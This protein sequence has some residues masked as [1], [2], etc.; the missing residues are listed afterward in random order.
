LGRLKKDDPLYFPEERLKRVLREADYPPGLIDRLI[1]IAYLPINRTDL[2]KG[3]DR[4]VVAEKEALE[5]L[6]RLGYSPA[7]A[8]LLRDILFSDKRKKLGT[9]SGQW[10]PRKITKEFRAGTITVRQAH[11]LLTNWY[12]NVDTALKVLEDAVMIREAETKALCI[13]AIRRRYMTGGITLA[14]ADGELAKLSIDDTQRE[15]LTAR[16]GCE[17]GSKAKE[18]TVRYIREWYME[19]IVSAGEFFTRLVFLGYNDNDAEKIV[20]TA[21]AKLDAA[22]RRKEAAALRE[23]QRAAEKAR[24]EMEA[25]FKYCDPSGYKE[26]VCRNGDGEDESPS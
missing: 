11:D 1:A 5:R 17:F 25:R 23:A 13:K 22:R 14:M 6:M 2:I 24:K 3:I 9:Q 15:A 21:T 8:E 20:D 16:W 4:G 19:G 7:D 26:S 18:P 12:G 10:T